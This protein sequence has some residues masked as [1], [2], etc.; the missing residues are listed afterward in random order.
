[1][2]LLFAMVKK[3]KHQFHCQ[4]CTSPCDIYKK[5]KNHRVL[6]CPNCGVLATNP[7][8]GKLLAKRGAKALLGEIPGASLIM[9]GV[10][11]VS[12]IRKNKK[13][14]ETDLPRKII[15]DSLDKPNRGERTINRVLYGDK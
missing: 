8:V 4:N 13:G 9:E 3:R 5:G 15:S 12:D 11:A 6:V 1:M 10:G 14:N 2:I 7:K